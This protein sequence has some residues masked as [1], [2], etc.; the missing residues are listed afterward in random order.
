MTSDKKPLF[1]AAG[2]MIRQLQLMCLFGFFPFLTTEKDLAR[3]SLK[4]LLTLSLQDSVMNSEYPQRFYVEEMTGCS[5]MVDNLHKESLLP[6]GVPSVYQQLMAPS[7]L[8][9]TD[10]HSSH[11]HLD[12][13]IS[14]GKATTVTAI[15]HPSIS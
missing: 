15:T 9:R 7:A 5:R 3:K 6:Q 12:L 13:G 2:Q 10:T 1:F 14:T 4:L 8:H 11:S